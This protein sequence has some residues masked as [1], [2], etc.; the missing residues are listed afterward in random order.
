MAFM[1]KTS[2]FWLSASMTAEVAVAGAGA[3]NPVG[4][5]ADR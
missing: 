3:V 1:L 5:V 4:R 2:W